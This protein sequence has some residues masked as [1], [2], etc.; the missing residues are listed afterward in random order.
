MRVTVDHT[1]NAAYI[2][3]REIEYSGV[4]Q[5]HVLGPGLPINLDFD[6][7]G[8]LVGIEVLNLDLLP[9]QVLADAE[10]ITTVARLC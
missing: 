5:T 8:K 6:R 1:A 2:Y 7:W 9:S 3:L 4:A 10:D